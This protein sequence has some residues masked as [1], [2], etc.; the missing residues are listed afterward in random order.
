MT[1][2]PSGFLAFAPPDSVGH[3]DD[4]LSITGQQAPSLSREPLVLPAPRPVMTSPTTTAPVDADVSPE[5]AVWSEQASQTDPQVEDAR[6]T[7]AGARARIVYQPSLDGVR[8]IGLLF[9]LASHAGFEFA[10]GGFLW[11]SAFFTFRAT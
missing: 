11:V 6:H 1:T 8:G 3:F 7:T 2:V 5:P 9:V 4:K 10:R